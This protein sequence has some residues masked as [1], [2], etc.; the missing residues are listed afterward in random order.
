MSK[1]KNEYLERTTSVKISVDF[2]KEWKE[3]SLKVLKIP[4]FI[5]IQLRCLSSYYIDKPSTAFL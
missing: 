2:A 1:F 4:S 3:K 5:N